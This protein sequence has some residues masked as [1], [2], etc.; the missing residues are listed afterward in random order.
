MANKSRMVLAKTQEINIAPKILHLNSIEITQ[1][2][3][4]SL[5]WNMIN[6]QISS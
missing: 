5:I 4:L 3:T 1:V 6:P 2:N